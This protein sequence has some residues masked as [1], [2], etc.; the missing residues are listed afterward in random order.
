MQGSVSRHV[1]S[2][3]QGE[4]EG[5]QLG[6]G[7]VSLSEEEHSGSMV[8]NGLRQQLKQGWLRDRR[9]RGRALTGAQNP[10]WQSVTWTH[11]QTPMQRVAPCWASGRF[12]ATNLTAR[13]AASRAPQPPLHIHRRVS[14]Q[15]GGRLHEHAPKAACQERWRLPGSTAGDEEPRMER[16]AHQRGPATAGWLLSLSVQGADCLQQMGL[17]VSLL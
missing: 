5:F 1:S 2:C 9:G 16:A 15:P 10:R 8:Q 14:D 3:E 17:Y 4:T 11:Q 7:V 6:K 13:P 12:W